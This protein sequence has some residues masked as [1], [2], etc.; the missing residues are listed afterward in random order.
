MSDELNKFKGDALTPPE[1]AVKAV[2]ILVKKAGYGF[3]TTFFLAILGGFFIGLGAMAATVAGT[4]GSSLPYGVTKILMGLMFSTG[5]ILIIIGGGELFTGNCLMTMAVLHKKVTLVKMLRNWGIAYLGNFVGALLL[6]G[7]M[8][9]SRQF[10]FGNGEVGLF[11]LNIAETKSALAFGS[12]FGLGILCNVLVCLAVWLS[13]SARTVA[14]K[15]LAII[16]PITVFVAAGFEHSIANMYFIPYAWLIKNFAEPAFFTTI[17]K[18][19]ADFTNL[20]IRNLFLANLLPVTL[21]NI[22]GGG[23][24]IGGIYW[25]VYLRKDKKKST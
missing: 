16:P 25:F 11:A 9:L 7:L 23:L 10:T 4:G 21:G 15:M 12:A 3:W 17:G 19:P 24:I 2:D 18:T 20:T 22:I 14:G 6:A 13:W 8:L 1:I 5:L